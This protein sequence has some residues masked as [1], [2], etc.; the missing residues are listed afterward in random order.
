M[1]CIHASHAALFFFF[2]F[3]PFVCL[4]RSRSHLFTLHS[5]LRATFHSCFAIRRR[6]TPV[7]CSPYF[8]GLLERG[9]STREEGK[10]ANQTPTQLNKSPTKPG[11]VFRPAGAEGSCSSS[12]CRCSGRARAGDARTAPGCAALQ[13]CPPAPGSPRRPLGL[14]A[15]YRGREEGRE[16]VCVFRFSQKV[17]AEVQSCPRPA[18][19]GPVP[20]GGRARPARR[21]S[22]TGSESRSRTPC[23]PRRRCR[24]RC[25]SRTSRRPSA[26]S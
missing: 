7:L 22:P 26:R 15:C 20:G 5:C 18:H 25:A 12:V 10:K 11:A 16:G 21:L 9:R 23:G 24:A 1:R 4:F 6:P 14:G 3:C 13:G 17:A 19:E 8:P 2:F